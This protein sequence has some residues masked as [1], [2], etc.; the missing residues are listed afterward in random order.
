[1]LRHLLAL[2]ALAVSASSMS[3]A[4]PLVPPVLHLQV[5]AKDKEAAMN[6]KVYSGEYFRVDYTA[7]ADG[8]L[9]QIYWT[10]KEWQDFAKFLEGRKLA[11]KGSVTV[12]AGTAD[13]AAVLAEV[14]KRVA[15]PAAAKATK[16]EEIRKKLEELRN[17]DKKKQ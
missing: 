13:A 9:Q 8:K 11:S 15:A 2:A 17:A 5:P 1:M 6:L 4:P 12:V 10:P 3:A 16:D 7:G 14:Q